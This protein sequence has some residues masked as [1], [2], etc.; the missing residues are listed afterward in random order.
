M[1]LD[2]LWGTGQIP[3]TTGYLAHTVSGASVEKPGFHQARFCEFGP[4]LSWSLLKRSREFMTAQ[5]L[6]V[7][8]SAGEKEWTTGLKAGNTGV[9]QG[10]SCHQ[11]QTGPQTGCLPSRAGPSLAHVDKEGPLFACV[12]TMNN[13]PVAQ[14]A[15]KIWA[16]I[17][18][19]CSISLKTILRSLRVGDTKGNTS[20]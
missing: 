5:T 8:H 18:W 12:L 2:I 6:A 3:I 4:G 1:L 13:E 17:P 10:M 11:R 16:K 9:L 20:C 15:H 14:K 7:A 19:L